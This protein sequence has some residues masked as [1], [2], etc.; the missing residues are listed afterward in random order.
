[1]LGRLRGK[2]LTDAYHFKTEYKLNDA[3]SIARSCEQAG[4]ENLD[5]RY[6]DPPDRFAAYLPRGLKWIAPAGSR[7]MYATNSERFLGML[8]W[9]AS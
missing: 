5:L 9:R 6:F 1:L 8:M 7:T 4:F 3:R 2:Q